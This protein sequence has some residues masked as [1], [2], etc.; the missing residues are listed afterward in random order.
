M[1]RESAFFKSTAGL[2]IATACAKLISSAAR[3]QLL[4]IV[5]PVFPLSYKRLLLVIGSLELLAAVVICFL[6]N[7]TLKHIVIIWLAGCF[8]SYRLAT[9][10]SGS[11]H[12]CP[13]LGTLGQ[14]TGMNQN[15][16]NGALYSIIGYLL[17]GSSW[18]MFHRARANSSD[19]TQMPLPVKMA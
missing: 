7:P 1:N 8:L 4:N 15:I 16:I 10:L 19:A 9:Y 6:K 14:W 3:S 17:L 5:D 12:F 11:S 13:C 2:L 18:F